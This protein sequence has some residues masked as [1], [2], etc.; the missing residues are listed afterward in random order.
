MQNVAPHKFEPAASGASSSASET[1]GTD[2]GDDERLYN[3]NWQ[4]SACVTLERD[5]I[6][7]VHT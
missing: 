1:A 7:Q 6:K 2:S 4:D 3:T 5:D